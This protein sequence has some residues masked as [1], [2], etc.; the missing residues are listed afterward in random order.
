[1]LKKIKLNKDC[2]PLEAIF[3]TLIGKLDTFYFYLKFDSKKENI[4]LFLTPKKIRSSQKIKKEIQQ[5]LNDLIE[6]SL[7]FFISKRNSKI[8]EYIVKEALFFSKSYRELSEEDTKPLFEK[9]PLGIA[10]PW[11]QNNNK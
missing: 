11:S 4:I 10:K 9:D 7:R 3:A 8:R 5:L 6:N 2:Y 1:V